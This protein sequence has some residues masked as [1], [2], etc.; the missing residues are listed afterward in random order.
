M[1]FSS[2]HILWFADTPE[3][4]PVMLVLPYTR[5]PLFLTALS[6]FFLEI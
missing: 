3:F 1:G 2:S 6:V 4:I 5:I